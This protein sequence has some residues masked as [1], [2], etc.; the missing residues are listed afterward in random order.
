MPT[1][2][3][4]EPEYALLRKSKLVLKLVL[5]GVA[6]STTL[7][8]RHKSTEEHAAGLAFGLVLLIAQGLH[9]FAFQKQQVLL[10]ALHV[11]D[12]PRA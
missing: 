8:I 7:K 3:T 11:A 10:L 5:K 6:T 1:Q 4:I 9:E 2:A 12:H